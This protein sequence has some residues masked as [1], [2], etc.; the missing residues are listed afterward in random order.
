MKDLSDYLECT[1]RAVMNRI[2]EFPELFS[3]NESMVKMVDFEGKEKGLI[4]VLSFPSQS[5]RKEKGSK[6]RLFLSCTR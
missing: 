4:K 5:G 6:S 2:K 1:E 3:S